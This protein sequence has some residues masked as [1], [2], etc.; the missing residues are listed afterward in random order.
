MIHLT[1]RLEDDREHEG[2]AR[3]S[4][5]EHQVGAELDWDELIEGRL[6]HCN[7]YVRG[8]VEVEEEPEKVGTRLGFS[9]NISTKLL[10]SSVGIGGTLSAATSGG[11]VTPTARNGQLC[12]SPPRSTLRRSNALAIIRKHTASLRGVLVGCVA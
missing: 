7:R 11:Q 9:R 5:L 12:R 3:L 2:A 1:L 10:Y 8:D 4:E 6:D